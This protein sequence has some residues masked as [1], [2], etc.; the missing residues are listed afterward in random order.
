ML[1]RDGDL[2][3]GGGGGGEKGGERV[4]ARPRARTRKTKKVVDRR[5]NNSKLLIVSNLFYPQSTSTVISR[6]YT[7]S[8]HT[9]NARNMYMLKVGKTQ[10]EPKNI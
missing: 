5:Q 7:F 10:T 4:K 2:G 6:Q 1:I 3:G 9:I 8:Q